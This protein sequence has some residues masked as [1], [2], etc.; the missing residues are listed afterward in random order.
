MYIPRTIEK[1]AAEDSAHFPVL[2]LTGARQTGKTTLL[3]HLAGKDREYISLDD[4]DER[5]MANKDPAYFARRL[6]TPALIAEIQCAPKLL[7]HIKMAVGQHNKPVEFWLTGSQQFHMMNNVAESL[8]GRV[9]ILELWGLS[10]WEEAQMRASRPVFMPAPEFFTKMEGEPPAPQDLCRL[11]WRGSPPQLAGASG[12]ERTRFLKSCVKTYLE[13][14]VRDQAQVKDLLAFE[15]FLSICAART[16]QPLNMAS[17]AKRRGALPGNREKMAVHSDSYMPSLPSA[18]MFHQQNQNLAKEPKLHFLDTGAAA[19]LAGWATPE[20]LEAGA[21]SGAFF[22]T[23]VIGELMTNW[24]GN[25]LEPRFFFCRDQ[26]QTETALLI[27][28]TARFALWSSGKPPHRKKMMCAI[29]KC[30]RI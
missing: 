26:D 4:L 20:A 10:R 2:M 25:G 12:A 28:R 18:A 19:H 6:E 30:W 15:R 5:E 11:I 1:I 8:A 24:L 29:F 17:L 7:P 21:R 13:R 14:D 16:G 27:A 3:R 22:E 9:D 23:W